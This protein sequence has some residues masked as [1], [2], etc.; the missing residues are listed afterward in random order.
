MDS[1]KIKRIGQ[2]LFDNA[3]TIEAELAKTENYRSMTI[4]FNMF[5]LSYHKMGVTLSMYDEMPYLEYLK[6][7]DIC[8]EKFK[9]LCNQTNEDVGFAPLPE[10]VKLRDKL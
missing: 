2:F 10:P 8:S 7:D 1:D 5:K 4:S 9:Q 6:D 3:E